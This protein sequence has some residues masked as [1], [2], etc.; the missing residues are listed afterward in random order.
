M[1]LRCTRSRSLCVSLRCCKIGSRTCAV[2]VESR[3][4][5]S[6][7]ENNTQE[8]SV[9]RIDNYCIN[10]SVLVTTNSGHATADGLHHRKSRR[11][12]NRTIFPLS[13]LDSSSAAS[14][15]VPVLFV[16][17]SLFYFLFLRSLLCIHLS[18][19]Y[20]F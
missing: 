10:C 9:K 8:Y 19:Y 1:V 16:F 3:P 11:L 13:P 20:L 5:E 12:P 17:S 4:I 15:C 6:N 7:V 14:H 18:F 2:R